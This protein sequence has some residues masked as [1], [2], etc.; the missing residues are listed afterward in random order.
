MGLGRANNEN[1]STS[2]DQAVQLINLHTKILH[3][4]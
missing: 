4:F 3:W 2:A 1:N